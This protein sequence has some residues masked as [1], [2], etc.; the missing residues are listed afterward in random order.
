MAASSWSQTVSVS[1]EEKFSPIFVADSGALLIAV[2]LVSVVFGGLVASFARAAGSWVNPGMQL[3]SPKSS[4]AWIG[5]ALGLVL[6]IVAGAILANAVGTPIEGTEGLV[7]LPVLTTLIIMLLGGALLGGVTTVVTQ[8]FGVP[9]SVEESDQA[10]VTAVRTRLGN[11]IGI[12]L[13]GLVLLALL[14]L[15]FAWTLIESNH[16]TSGGAA[17]VAIITASGILAFAS[18]AGSRPNMK[19]GLGEFLIAVAGIGI[20]V[21]MLFAVLNNLGG[22]EEEEPADEEAGIELVVN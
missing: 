19:I 9:A 11:A 18:L 3:Q 13:A 1:G 21:L 17:I 12:P 20:V 6:G 2:A 4:T 10:E 8:F 7:E 14:V 22:S 5:G 15:P 16:L